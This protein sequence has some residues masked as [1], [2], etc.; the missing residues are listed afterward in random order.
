MTL[1]AVDESHEQLYINESLADLNVTKG[2]L[3]IVRERGRVIII[4]NYVLFSIHLMQSISDGDIPAVYTNILQ[5]LRYEHND[6]L[7]GN[8]TKGNR[9]VI[10]S[11]LA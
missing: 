1:F 8:P 11:I 9:W 4:Y 3:I 5:S 7:P 10:I 2:Q 6:T